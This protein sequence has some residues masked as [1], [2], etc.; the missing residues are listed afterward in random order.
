MERPYI[1]CHMATALDGKITGPF[2]MTES[3]AA[4]SKEYERINESY[5]PQAWLCGRVTTDENFTMYRKPDLDENAPDVP[6][7]DY[8][9]VKGAKM[10]YVSVDASG[11]IGWT[12]NTLCYSNRPAAH[13][14]EVLTEKASNA[15]RAYLRKLNIS[16]IIAGKDKL[17]CALA[18]KKLK[19]LF[20]IQTLMVSGGGF[21]NWSF[22][23]S[24]LIDELSL[25]I[26]P[27][28][29]GETDTVTLFEKADYL[30]EKAPVEFSL[31]DVEK[32]EGDGVW[33]RYTVKK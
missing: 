24:G 22:L 26:A 31:K 27:V 14:I 7:G 12:S 17:D 29:D 8:V 21:I 15:Y 30:P 9:A 1:V 20:D 4:M 2:M 33:L 6:E 16:Y 5:S 32:L 3:A 25:I 11:R 28:A 18:A 23:E 10:H 19:E 13:I